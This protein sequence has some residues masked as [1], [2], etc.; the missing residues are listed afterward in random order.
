MLPHVVTALKRHDAVDD[1][2]NRLDAAERRLAERDRRP[3]VAG[4]RRVLSL[5]RRLEFDPETK[6]A[7]GAELERVLVGAGYVEFGEAGEAFDPDRHEVVEGEA[8]DGAAVVRK[9]FE[10]GLETL[11]D[12]V[13]RAKVRVGTAEEE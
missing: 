10:P 12:V 2:S 7:I 4:L 11:G 6:A 1:L 5:V 3:L 13:V 8:E 9:L